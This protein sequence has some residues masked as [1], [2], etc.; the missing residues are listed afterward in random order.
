MPNKVT[1]LLDLDETTF[2]ALNQEEFDKYGDNYEHIKQYKGIH[3]S[4]Q[5]SPYIECSGYYFFVI[6]PKKFKQMVEAI[7]RQ[8]QDIVIFTSGLWPPVVLEIVALLCN[9]SPKEKQKFTHSLLL[10]VQHDCKELGMLP[11][12][13]RFMLKPYRLHG[14]FRSVKELRSRHFV[15][16]DDNK[17]HIDC[18]ADCSYLDGVQATVATDDDSFYEEVVRKMR[19]GKEADL[20][21]LS[22]ASSCYYYPKNIL[23]YFINLCGEQ[24]EENKSDITPLR[25]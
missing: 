9:L 14:L 5:L 11:D 12:T 10:N 17:Y 22:P 2:I 7:Y 23:R 19:E 3:S 20:S 6:N 15:L 1:L 13:V 16:L 4:H 18:C 21:L 8:K 25:S 24:L